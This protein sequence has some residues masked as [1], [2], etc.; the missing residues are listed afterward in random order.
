MVRTVEHV[1]KPAARF[2]QLPIDLKVDRIGR[3]STKITSSDSGLVTDHHQKVALLAESFQ[4]LSRL[5]QQ[6]HLSGIMQIGDMFYQRPV[7]VEQG[8]SRLPH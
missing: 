2:L 5:G 6:L 4:A 8:D 1:V 7:P 3:P